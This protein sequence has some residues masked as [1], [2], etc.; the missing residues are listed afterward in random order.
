MATTD[1]ALAAAEA[2][3]SN[4]TELIAALKEE[5]AKIDAALKRLLGTR[6]VSAETKA[7]QAASAKKRWAER[8]S[9]PATE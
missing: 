4:R 9:P 3:E 2:L 8:N 5:R 1:E 7:K 6:E